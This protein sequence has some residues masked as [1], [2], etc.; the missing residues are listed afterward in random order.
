MIERALPDGHG[1]YLVRLARGW[2]RE[3]TAKRAQITYARLRLIEEG[4]FAPTV[5]E[6][7]RLL[8]ALS[9][10]PVQERH[11]GSIRRVGQP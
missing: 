5:A 3:L 2:S 10:D 11:D 6:T 4:H 7:A 8:A 9:S 1:L